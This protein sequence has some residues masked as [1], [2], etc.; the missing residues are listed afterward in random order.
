MSKYEHLLQPL[1]IGNVIFRNRLFTAPM[2]LHA[3]Q[4]GESYPTDAI[5][6]HYANKARGGAAVVTL[7]GTGSVP[8]GGR[9]HEHMAYNLFE[10]HSQHYLAQ[11]IDAIHFYGAKVSMEIQ[12]SCKSQGYDVSAGMPLRGGPGGGGGPMGGGQDNGYSGIKPASQKTAGGMP[13]PGGPGGPGGGQPE[14]SKEMTLAVMQEYCDNF[15][16]QCEVLQKLGV[17]MVM[18]HMA[19]EMNIMSR[20]ITPH[21]NHRT[22]EFGG[23]MENRCRFLNMVFDAIHQRCGRDFLIELRMSGELPEEC[24]FT[25]DDAVEM[26]RCLVG[27]LDIL[28]VHAPTAWQAHPMCFEPDMPNLHL[29]ENIKKHVPEMTVLTIGGYQ[30]LDAIDEII[31]SGKADLVSMARGWLADPEL[32]RKAYEGRGDDVRPCIKCMRCHDSACIDGITFVCTVNPEIGLEHSLGRMITP[33]AQPKKVAVVG[34]GPAGMYAAL[35]AAERGHSVTLYE[36]KDHLGGQ[37]NFADYAKFKS[38]LK[39]YKNWLIYQLGKRKVRVVLGTAADKALLLR[40]GYEAVIAA[41]GANPLI[42]PVP[43]HELAVPAPQVYG[44]E[45]QLGQQVVVIGAGQ[46]GCETAYHLC[47]QGHSVKIVEMQAKA[48]PDA[49]ASYRSRLLRFMGY[50]GD[51]IEFI[52]EARCKEITAQGLVYTDKNGEDVLLPCDSVVMAAGMRPNQAAA[53]E[54]YDPS[55]RLYLIGDCEKTANVQK[56]IR[57]AY[58]VAMTL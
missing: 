28:H 11:A 7:S 23:S 37:L 31:A 53:M 6:A 51:R 20:F 17:D 55:Y 54:L 10:G 50:E 2:G 19:Y 58:S 38:A 33:V 48:A 44:H 43:G 12:G 15:A 13:G 47:Q 5:I 22:D 30:D 24:G 45:D 42:L 34:G 57:R 52:L 36:A 25:N 49:S 26:A 21:T 46:V 27:H 4:G 35:R 1:K 56:A 3:L 8:G 14:L 40:E 16:D 9:D 18:I 29:A 39:K 32:G 41:V